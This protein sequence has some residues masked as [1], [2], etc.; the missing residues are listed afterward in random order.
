M[1]IKIENTQVFGWEGAIRG[2]RNPMNSWEKSDSVFKYGDDYWGIDGKYTEEQH[3]LVCDAIVKG[4]LDDS[5]I[6]GPNDY[7]LLMN[8]CKGGSE[9][10]KWRRMIH[11]QMDITAPLYW[12][13]ELDTYKVGTVRNSC[14]F[15]HKGL[16]KP[17]DI[18]DFSIQNE[19]I[20]TILNPIVSEEMPLVYPYE[21]D[22][23]RIYECENGR[24]Y[25]VFSNGR[26]YA[27][28]FSYIDSYG[29]G[30][31]RFFSEKEVHPTKNALGYYELNIGGR[32]GE[33][34]LLHRLVATLW[35][36]NPNAYETVNHIDGNKGNNS[37]E[38]LE[39][40]S[41]EENIKKGFENGLYDKNQLHASYIK[42]KRGHCISPELK[43]HIKEDYKKGLKG[44]ALSQKYGIPI[45]SINNMLFLKESKYNELF[46]E[47]YTWEKLIDKL[48]NLRAACIETKDNNLFQ[49]LRQLLPCGYNQRFTWDT[50]YE[51]LA[52]I[53]RQRKGHRLNEWTAFR[54]MITTLP[55][56]EFITMKE[57]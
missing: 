14:S 25:K 23:Y 27:K 50:N 18:N 12:I 33:K 7:K 53:Y 30:R 26:V 2:A 52:S 37:Y 38:N 45:K 49:L 44:T 36:P 28:E 11:V 24:E 42:W 54:D 22:E 31:E 29:T 16:S 19:N 6:I 4:Q 20:Y 57:E 21:T 15:M 39:W 51:V 41:R 48:N 10:A 1:S 13:S 5:C 43:W 55:Y 34:W 46:Y 40:C 32:A 8:L 35:C 56:S 47:A 9:E 17:F 3:N